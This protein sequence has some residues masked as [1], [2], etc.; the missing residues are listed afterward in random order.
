MHRLLMPSHKSVKLPRAVQRGSFVSVLSSAL[1]PSMHSWRLRRYDGHSASTLAADDRA[2]SRQRVSQRR[3][4]VG[5]TRCGARSAACS[6]A[7]RCPASASRALALSSCRWTAVGMAWANGRARV[8]I[9]V[10]APFVEAHI[11]LT[12]LN[13]CRR[14]CSSCA[15]SSLVCL[16][17]F[18]SAFACCSERT[19]LVAAMVRRCHSAARRLYQR[20]RLRAFALLRVVC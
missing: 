3:V 18:F 12:S 4:K 7:S 10:G 14:I 6:A 17:R 20:S 11:A 19:P 5:P 2:S 1:Y 13:F 9:A 8:G 16:I 15:F